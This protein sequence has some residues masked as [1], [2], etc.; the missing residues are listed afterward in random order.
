MA[1]ATYI[2]N[3]ILTKAI[4]NM[5]SKKVWC[6]YKPSIDHLHVFIC[7]AFAHVPKEAMAKLDFK[8]VKCIFISYCENTKGYRLYNPISQYVIIS[9][10]CYF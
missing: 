6:G 1:I 5:T 7:V 2:H 8:G 3:Q 9:Q 4:S 10:S